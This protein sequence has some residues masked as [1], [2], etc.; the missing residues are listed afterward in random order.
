[1]RKIISNKFTNK[2]FGVA[3]VAF[4]KSN[5]FAKHQRGMFLEEPSPLLNKPLK[6]TSDTDREGL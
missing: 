5:N 2:P 6:P 3:Y 1:M 4:P